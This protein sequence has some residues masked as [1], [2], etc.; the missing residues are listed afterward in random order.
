MTKLTIYRSEHGSYNE[1]LACGGLYTTSNDALVPEFI[2]GDLSLYL[3]DIYDCIRAVIDASG[4]DDLICGSAIHGIFWTLEDLIN[5]A[6]V[7]GSLPEKNYPKEVS[8]LA[9]LAHKGCGLIYELFEERYNDSIDKL[10]DGLP[11]HVKTQVFKLAKEHGFV[12]PQQRHAE[13][14][15]ESNNDNYCRHGIDRDCCPAGCGE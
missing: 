15:F 11:Q 1:A 5:Y 12:E 8:H 4:R 13:T 7:H 6:S 2:S 14:M 9:E 10:V 3:S